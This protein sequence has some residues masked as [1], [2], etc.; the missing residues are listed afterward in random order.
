MK[1][2]NAPFVEANSQPISIHQPKGVKSVGISSIR[3]VGNEDVYN[4]EV[5]DTHCYTA[6]G[7]VVHN[8]CDAM[9]YFTYTVMKKLLRYK[10]E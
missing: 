2:E 9:R 1:R 3:K 5:E 6:N 8:C 7:I 4:M 10:V